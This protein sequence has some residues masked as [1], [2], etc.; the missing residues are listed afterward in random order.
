M[1]SSPS[2]CPAG[3]V[4]GTCKC[5]LSCEEIKQGKSCQNWVPQN[6][7]P[8]GGFHENKTF[9]WF[10]SY[11][12]SLKVLLFPM[13]CNIVWNTIHHVIIMSF[14]ENVVIAQMITS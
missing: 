9:C 14:Q 2:V 12:N 10:S 5:V 4:Y 6:V 11:H 13:S 8:N 1:P 3:L 7:D